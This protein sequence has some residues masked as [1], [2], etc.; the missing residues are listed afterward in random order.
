MQ[1]IVQSDDILAK[2]AVAGSFQIWSKSDCTFFQ[3]LENTFPMLFTDPKSAQR[4]PR[5][6]PEKGRNFRKSAARVDFKCLGR[7]PTRL[8]SVCCYLMVANKT[9]IWGGND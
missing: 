8:T 5:Y 3:A 9:Q 2:L 6:L 7:L 4:F 1:K